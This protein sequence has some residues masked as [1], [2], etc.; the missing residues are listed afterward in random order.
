M[1]LQKQLNINNTYRVLNLNFYH[2]DPA[3][4]IV[5]KP[6]NEKRI[7]QTLQQD[8]G[9]GYRYLIKK[10]DSTNLRLNALLYKSNGSIWYYTKDVVPFGTFLDIGSNRNSFYLYELQDFNKETLD[11]M[12]TAMMVSTVAIN[13][14]HVG[15]DFNSLD[16]IYKLNDVRFIADRVYL[17]FNKDVSVE[18]KERI[19]DDLHEVLARWTMQ[20]YLKYNDEDE[21]QQLKTDIINKY[22]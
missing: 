14:T 11:N 19:F 5:V 8:R 2:D 3:H 22:N 13:V 21:L 9:K 4:T 6:E 16:L 7:Y 17:D 20:L 18:D 1:R 12:N 10:D 15:K